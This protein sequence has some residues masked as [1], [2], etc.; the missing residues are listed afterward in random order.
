MAPGSCAAAS[1]WRRCSSGRARASWCQQAA[2]E[3]GEDWEAT[4]LGVPGCGDAGWGRGR[5]GRHRS[6]GRRDD[7]ARICWLGWGGEAAGA[8]LVPTETKPA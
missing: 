4:V 7:S 2:A 8:D 1:G 5:Q 6:G 3:R